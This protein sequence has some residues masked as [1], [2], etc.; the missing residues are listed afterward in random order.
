MKA[1]VAAAAVRP[2][3]PAAAAAS[4]P[5][6]TLLF[7]TESTPRGFPTSSTKSVACPPSCRPSLAP[8]SA[9]MAGALQ[10]P[11]KCSPPRQLVAQPG[12]H[13]SHVIGLFGAARPIQYGGD[14]ALGEL[15][16]R[17][18]AVLTQKFQQTRLA[19]FAKLI[20]RLSDAVAICHQQIAG[21]KLDGAFVVAD[22]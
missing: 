10:G 3:G 9:Y 21:A 5:S 12:Q 7:S 15:G 8:S 2:L 6:F 19:K 11:V 1:S 22:L 4:A 14:D 13:Q 18:A 20:F 17:Q 16:E